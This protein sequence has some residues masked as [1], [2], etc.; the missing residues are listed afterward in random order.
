MT[1]DQKPIL[2]GQSLDA[3]NDADR[4]PAA[5]EAPPPSRSP[6]A[7]QAQPR[8]DVDESEVTYRGNTTDLSALGALASSAL[9]LLTCLT[10]GSGIYCLPVVPLVLGLIGVLGAKRS[11]NKE[12]TRLFSWIGI[13]TGGL[14]ILLIIA[15]FVIYLLFVLSIVLI[16]QEGRGY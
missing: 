3:P 14:S 12:Q 8:A 13:G 2:P 11:V 15:G 10:C 7:P 5:P 16:A 1:K 6:H 4:R 9:L